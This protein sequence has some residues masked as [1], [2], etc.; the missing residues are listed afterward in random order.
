MINIRYFAAAR[1]AS[2]VDAEK[3]EHPGSLRNL[4]TVLAGAHGPRLATVLSASSFLVDGLAWHDRDAELPAGCTVDV[5]PPF[6]GG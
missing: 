2:G 1:A 5:L 4:L 3:A 6:A